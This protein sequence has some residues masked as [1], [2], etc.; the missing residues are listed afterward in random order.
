MFIVYILKSTKF[1]ERHYVGITQNIA[2]RIKEHNDGDM[3]YSSRYAPW[4][5]ETC[6][7]F[8]DKHL[9]YEFEKYLKAGSG[10][11]FLKKRLFNPKAK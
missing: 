1:P 4:E 5:V 2:K 10:Y 8:R 11:A 6:I 3:E 7:T 9:A